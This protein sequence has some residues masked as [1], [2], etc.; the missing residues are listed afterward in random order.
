MKTVENANL[1]KN[2][3]NNIE[4]IKQYYL[5]H[6]I[7]QTASKYGCSS[8]TL[9]RLLRDNGIIKDTRRKLNDSEVYPRIKELLA[10]NYGPKYICT[11][12][13]ISNTTYHRILNK[14]ELLNRDAKLDENSELFWYILGF[15]T[16]DG[17]RT[18]GWTVYL[19]QSN[20]KFLNMLKTKLNCGNIGTPTKGVYKYYFYSSILL[21]YLN[22]YGISTNKSLSVPFIKAPSDELQLAY[23]RGV[24]DG[25]GCISYTFR[26]YKF[27]DKSVTI[28]SGSKDFIT[29]LSK[30]LESHN[31]SNIIRTKWGSKNPYYVI[32]INSY[33]AIFKFAHI[34]Y[35]NCTVK[36]QRKFISFIKLKAIYKINNIINN[37]YDIVD[38]NTEM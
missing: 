33:E 3:Q 31:V 6:T 29:E 13:K 34:I 7:Q 38:D 20:Y 25:D 2:L 37:K 15:F 32:E 19:S 21:K 26:S 24:F 36:L 5:N 22:A 4:E 9:Q 14:Y 23:I 11:E 35:K 8:A 28:V 12:L 10:L 30:Y 18:E 1:R 27:V 16:A 17:H